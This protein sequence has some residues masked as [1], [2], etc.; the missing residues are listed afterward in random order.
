MD[1]DVTLYTRFGTQLLVGFAYT[2][3]IC[4]L[5]NIVALLLGLSIAL[6]QTVPFAPIRW[7][8][9]SYIDV[10]RGTPLLVQ[11]FLLYYGGPSIGITLEPITAGIIGLAA[12]GGAYFA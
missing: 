1:F 12:Y 9:R 4:A 5:A 11:L 8:C 3:T 10:I 7:C 2:V 6:L